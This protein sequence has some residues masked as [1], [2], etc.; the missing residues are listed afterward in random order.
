MASPVPGKRYCVIRV[1]ARTQSVP[2]D[3]IC[4]FNLFLHMNDGNFFEI[5][6]IVLTRINI[7][8]RSC[9]WN[10]CQEMKSKFNLTF[11]V[12][13]F[14]TDVALQHRRDEPKC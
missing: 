10:V 12:S 7:V 14:Y 1:D 3:S 2:T 13:S 4:F 11:L 8:V 5:N 6:I 9:K